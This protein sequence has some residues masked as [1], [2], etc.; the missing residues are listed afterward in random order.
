MTKFI[1]FVSSIFRICYTAF[2]YF[3]YFSFEA[4]MTSDEGLPSGED[5]SYLQAIPLR[6][7]GF[8]R[9][10]FVLLEH[11]STISLSLLPVKYILVSYL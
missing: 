6:G 11:K 7:T 1:I 4:N 8:H 9:Y 10:V 2:R 5:C 3:N